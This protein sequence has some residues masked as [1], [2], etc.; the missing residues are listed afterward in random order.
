MT[1]AILQHENTNFHVGDG[2]YF[3]FEGDEYKSS[4]TDNTPKFS[5]YKPTHLIMTAVSWDH[6]DLYPTEQSYFDVFKKLISDI[7]ENGIII[8]DKDD[9][10]V[11]KII[12]KAIFYGKESADYTYK[13]IKQ[14]IDIMSNDIQQ[15]NVE[16]KPKQI[17]NMFIESDYNYSHFNHIADYF[18]NTQQCHQQ[19]HDHQQHH[20]QQSVDR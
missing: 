7:P 2:H 6:A 19:P 1:G 13:N 17:N 18:E 8:A 4:P 10:G 3:V 14:T 9:E 5:Y 16:E 11:K 12:D 20:R 15:Q